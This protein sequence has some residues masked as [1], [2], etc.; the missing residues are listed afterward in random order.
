MLRR[1]LYTETAKEAKRLKLLKDENTRKQREL[2]QKIEAA[3]NVHGKKIA[4][5]EEEIRRLRRKAEEEA[6]Q[7]KKK[8]ID[9]AKNESESILKAAFN[10]KEKFREEAFLEMEKKAPLLASQIFKEV[11]SSGI[12]EAI[13][14]E[15]VE[16][17][18]E[19]IKRIEKSNFKVKTKKGE[20]ISA[21]SLERNE[22]SQLLSLIFEKLGHK[23]D[24]DEKE[25]KGL[26]AG[27]VISL[28]TLIIDG[29]LENRLKQ[30]CVTLS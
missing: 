12:K 16:R 25:N 4:E 20:I 8:I 19:E 27:V 23:I 3:E 30:I 13:H 15:L 18:I 2:Q 24:F 28:G 7:E 10:A 14:K 6:G 5:A 26:V 29:S 11:L 17:V 22:R 21:Y 9:K 1:F